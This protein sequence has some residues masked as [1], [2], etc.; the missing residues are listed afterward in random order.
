MPSKL[1]G[2][3]PESTPQ[4]ANSSELSNVE[5]YKMRV[6]SAYGDL[7]AVPAKRYKQGLAVA[8]G[9]D[10]KRTTPKRKT[11]KRTVVKTSGK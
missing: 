1:A 8:Q 9:L 7:R 11:R 3:K 5:K 6:K 2:F 10:A 4:D